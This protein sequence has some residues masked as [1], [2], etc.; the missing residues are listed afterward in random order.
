MYILQHL[1]HSQSQSSWQISKSNQQSPQALQALQL[2]RMLDGSIK[3]MQTTTKTMPKAQLKRDYME[4][5]TK[6]NISEQM[7]AVNQFTI[8]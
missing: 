6:G 3:K 7:T 1:S 2:R 8:V 4:E 5:N